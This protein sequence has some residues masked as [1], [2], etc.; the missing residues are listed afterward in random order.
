MITDIHL[1]IRTIDEKL[2]WFNHVENQFIFEFSDDG[3]PEAK[4]TASGFTTL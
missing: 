2:T 1:T 4:Y 3:A